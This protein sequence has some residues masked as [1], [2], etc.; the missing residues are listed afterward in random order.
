MGTGPLGYWDFFPGTEDWGRPPCWGFATV[1]ESDADAVE[2]GTRYYGFFPIAETLDVTPQRAGPRGFVDA[3]PHRHSKAAVY[4]QYL[5][6]AADPAYESQFEPEQVL[7]RP[8]YATGWWA[9]DCVLTGSPQTVVV[10]SAS[11]KTALSMVSSAAAD[12]RHSRGGTHL[13]A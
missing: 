4:N 10:S 1:V 11:A 12:G 7:F 2:A 9:A 3:A 5:N 8:L 6:V 13:R